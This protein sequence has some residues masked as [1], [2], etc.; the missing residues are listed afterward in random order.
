[1]G[2]QHSH[3]FK[4]VNRMEMVPILQEGREH[5][6][7]R[8]VQAGALGLLTPRNDM[9]IANLRAPNKR[10]FVSPESAHCHFLLS[11]EVRGVLA[12]TS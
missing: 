11:A 1:M 9:Q 6:A 7:L 3:S 10:S 12:I 5:R 4:D 8:K 2:R